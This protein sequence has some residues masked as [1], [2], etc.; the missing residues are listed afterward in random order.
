LLPNLAVI[1]GCCGTDHRHVHAMAKHA[2]PR[3]VAAG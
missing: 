1:G 3:L 2:L